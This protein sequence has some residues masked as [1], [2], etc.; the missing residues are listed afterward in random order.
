MFHCVFLHNTASR[1]LVCP[2]IW[3]AGTLYTSLQSFLNTAYFANREDNTTFKKRNLQIWKE[4]T[5]LFHDNDTTP[6]SD[7]VITICLN[8]MFCHK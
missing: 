3:R 2:Y 7:T 5:Q 4:K 8:Q 1:H 6:G